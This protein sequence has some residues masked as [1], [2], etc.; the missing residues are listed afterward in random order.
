MFMLL[1]FTWVP[2][3]LPT[4]RGYLYF[5]GHICNNSTRLSTYISEGFKELATN[6]YSIVIIICAS[7]L[8]LI[9]EFIATVYKNKY[10][11]ILNNKWF[12]IALILMILGFNYAGESSFIYGTF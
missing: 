2:F 8:L 1:A 12:I 7:L 3:A 10:S 11:K 5:L 6:P 4:T 9:C